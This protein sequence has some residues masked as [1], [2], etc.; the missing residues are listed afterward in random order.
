MINSTFKHFT[1]FQIAL[2]AFNVSYIVWFG[3]RYIQAINYEFMAYA[4][5]LVAIFGLLYLTLH[6]TKFP[7]YIVAGLTLW[8]L[9]HMMGGTL[10][11]A[12]GVLYAY[13]IFPLFDGGGDFYILKMDQVVHAFLYGVVALMFLHLLREIVGIKTHPVLIAFVAIMASTGFSVINEILEFTAV[14][15]LPETG[16]GGYYNTMLDM[17]FNMTG[18]IVAVVGYNL[19]KRQKN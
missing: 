9:F 11:T 6:I 8:G 13:R 12:D 14:L 7:T 19:L 3:L 1:S 18:A 2:L 17:V 16:V 10:Q 15:A 5:L 4:V